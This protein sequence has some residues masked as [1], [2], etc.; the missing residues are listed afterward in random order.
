[1]RAPSV[2]ETGF[3]DR[4]LALEEKTYRYV[5]YVPRGHDRTR[6]LPVLLF[7]HGAGERGDDG[8]RQTAVG[9]APAIR[10]RPERFPMIVVFPQ[11]PADTQWL[12]DQARFAI[13]AMERTAAEFGGDPD[14]FYLTGLSL[15]GYGTWHLALENPGRFAALIPVCGGIVKPETAQSVR[16]SALTMGASDPYAFTAERVGKTPVWIFHGADDGVIPASESRRMHEELERVGGRVRYTEYPGVGHNAWDP[17]YSE[18]A[19]WTW[20]LRQRLP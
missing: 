10:A 12:G 16:R 13:M 11:A 9:L 2:H 14:R 6:A 3:L 15:G 18:A 17:A 7:L 20:L 4:T 8:L 5:V 19:L 1:M